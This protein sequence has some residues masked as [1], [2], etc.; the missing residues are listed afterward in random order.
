MKSGEYSQR[1]FRNSKQFRA[2]WN[3]KII[4]ERHLERETVKCNYNNDICEMQ[5]VS[6]SK[7]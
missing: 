4:K 3:Y 6:K 2:P 7:L 1:R 5:Y